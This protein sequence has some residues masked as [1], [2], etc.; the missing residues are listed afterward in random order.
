MART[1]FSKSGGSEG[2]RWET[3][4]RMEFTEFRLYWEGRV[5]RGDI[6]DFFGISIP[7]A[8]IDLSKY[9]ELAPGNIEYDR[10]GKFYFATE[11]FQPLFYTPSSDD[12]LSHLK[13]VA[14]GKISN[15]NSIIKT[16]PENYLIPII[17]RPIPNEI[18][19]NLICSI[20]NKID[21]NIMYQSM[22]SPDPSLRWIAPQALAYDGFRW[23][24]R[25]HCFLH[26]D[27]R[28]FA[29]GRIW[30]VASQRPSELGTKEDHK[31]N[32]FINLKVGANPDL[33]DNQRKTIETEYGMENGFKE[34]IV[35]ESLLFYFLKKYGLEQNGSKKI[36]KSQ[37]IILLN[38]E[39]LPSTSL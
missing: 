18:L 13:Q 16:I 12:Y 7:Q 26:G 24:I 15:E 25:A 19:K 14:S 8:S 21:L 37:H 17:E 4:R 9:Q 23:H 20:K 35:R 34:V 2:L 30:E 32:N 29:I 3:H 31:W 38:P 39:N 1:K 28:D 5:N 36:A 33:S 27:F 22:N 11:N 10:S 6:T